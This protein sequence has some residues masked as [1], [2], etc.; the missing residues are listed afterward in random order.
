MP[1][2]GKRSQRTGEHSIKRRVG[3]KIFG[4]SLNRS[5]IAESEVSNHMFNEGNFPRVAIEQQEQPL[6]FHNRQR[7]ARKTCAGADIDDARTFE[8]RPKRQAVE[9]M[10]A[11]HLLRITDRSQVQ[12]FVPAFEFGKQ[13]CELP[14]RICRQRL[15]KRRNAGSDSL[16]NVVHELTGRASKQ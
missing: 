11:H 9:N 3:N 5:D 7:Q 12:S 4:A 15:A 6:R 13:T 2:P 1:C 8:I 10:P 16:F 14:N